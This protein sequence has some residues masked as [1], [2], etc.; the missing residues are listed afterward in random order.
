MEPE[1][2]GGMKPEDCG[3]A[4]DHSYSVGRNR[5]PPTHRFQKGQSGN[6]KGRPKRSTLT[7][8]IRDILAREHRGRTTDQVLVGVIIRQALSGKYPFVKELWDRLEGKPRARHEVEAAQ[9]GPIIFR[10]IE[11]PPR[12]APPV[13]PAP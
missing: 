10:F 2:E 7:E 8:R 11:T 1:H 4:P 3:G 12:D 5:P 6:P 13:P 9:R